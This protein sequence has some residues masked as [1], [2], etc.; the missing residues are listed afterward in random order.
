M[1]L[2][3]LLPLAKKFDYYLVTEGNKANDE[4]KIDDVNI[5]FLDQQERKGLIFFYKFIKNILLSL[6]YLIKE[7]PSHI[8]T[9]GAGA[10]FPTCLFGKMMG[11]K[12]VY[13]ES[14]AKVNSKSI[15]GSIIYKFS[16]KFYVQW[17]ETLSVYPKAEYH[18]TIY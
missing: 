15:T 3:Q 10:V 5:Y 13:I 8:I 7:K 11:C 14:F 1:E 2:L 18:G 17:E 4:L 6:I 12:I 16:D 9:T